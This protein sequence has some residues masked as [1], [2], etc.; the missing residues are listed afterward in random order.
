MGDYDEGYPDHMIQTITSMHEG[1]VISIDK[2]IHINSRTEII[3]QGVRQ[4]CPLS[5][6]PFST[7]RICTCI[8]R[9]FFDRN[10]P[11]KIG[12][13]LFTELKKNL[14]PPEKKAVKDD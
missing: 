13:R 8:S 11:S 6:T 2:G 14:H 4:G 3:N 10:L 7:Y 5:P 1:M 9:T 12:V